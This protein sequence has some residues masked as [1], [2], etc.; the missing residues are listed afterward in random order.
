M[1]ITF[2][3]SW[4]R[5]SNAGGSCSATT[6]AN[7]NLIGEGILVCQYGCPSRVRISTMLYR[8]TD[9]SEAENWSYGER[10]L[11]YNFT[12][13]APITIGFSG[14]AWIRPLVHLGIYPQ[15]SP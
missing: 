12:G 11:A 9:F 4:R 2:H 1:E 10:R 7:G 14:Y 3:I 13:T 5:D 6:I 8:C 15:H